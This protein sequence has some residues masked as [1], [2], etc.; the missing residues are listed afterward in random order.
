M[1]RHR[2]PDMEAAARRVDRIMQW[3]YFVMEYSPYHIKIQDAVDYWPTSSRWRDPM[4]FK[5]ERSGK[6]MESLRAYLRENYP[7]GWL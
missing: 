4:G 5:D 7:E 3:G 1:S 2:P 6:G